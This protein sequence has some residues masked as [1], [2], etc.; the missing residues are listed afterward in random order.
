MDSIRG[1]LCSRFF[2]ICKAAKFNP[3]YQPHFLNIIIM[4]TPVYEYVILSYPRFSAR[5]F[6]FLSNEHI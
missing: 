1:Q 4:S 5:N 2:N 3:L 6:I